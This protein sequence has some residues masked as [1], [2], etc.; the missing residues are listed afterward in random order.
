[1]PSGPFSLEM[2]P[3]RFESQSM[4]SMALLA[5][6][7]TAVSIQTNSFWAQGPTV[8]ANRSQVSFIFAWATS[9]GVTLAR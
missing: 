6:F 9:I 8:T 1:M 2:L 3:H 5:R 7:A 4:R